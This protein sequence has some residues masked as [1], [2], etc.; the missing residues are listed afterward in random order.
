MTDKKSFAQLVLEFFAEAVRTIIHPTFYERM[1]RDIGSSLGREVLRHVRQSVPASCGE[2]MKA[3]WGWEHEIRIDS[4]DEIRVLAPVCPFKLTAED[5][6]LCQ[7]EAAIFG[8]IAA[9]QFGYGKVVVERGAGAPPSHCRLTVYLERTPD[10]VTKEGPTFVP[11][12]NGEKRE[13][14]IDVDKAIFA[15]LSQRERQIIKLIAEGLSD[16]QI[17][18]ALHLSVRTVEGHVAR[19]R[20]KTSLRSRSAL[21]RFALRSSAI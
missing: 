9:D 19:I 21:I 14:D 7:V 5:S 11:G 4:P 8:S 15:K 18:E 3:H 12:R 1:L 16:K 20:D 6:L 13:K 10:S 17:A 2:W